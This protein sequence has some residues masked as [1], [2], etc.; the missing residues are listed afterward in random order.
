[1]KL[2]FHDTRARVGIRRTATTSV[3]MANKARGMCHPVKQVVFPLTNH[4]YK[5]INIQ[6]VNSQNDML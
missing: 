1:M 4:L 5:I 6:V 2:G 3:A